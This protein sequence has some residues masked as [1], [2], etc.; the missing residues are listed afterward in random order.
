MISAP[1]AGRLV[2]QSV[3]R[4]AAV[5]SNLWT[6]NK[7]GWS[8]EDR[9]LFLDQFR[10]RERAEATVRLYRSIPRRESAPA[11]RGTSR[12]DHLTVPTLMLNGEGDGAIRPP[13]VRGYEPHADDMRVEI[14]EDCGHFLPEE[15]PDVV[16]RRALDFFAT[17]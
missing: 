4:F 6:V 13:L 14:I 5:A 7:E 16:L 15:C 1:L 17:A 8:E 9:A 3:P 11:I 2:V 10:E 12:R